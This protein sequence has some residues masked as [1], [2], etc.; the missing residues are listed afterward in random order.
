MTTVAPS[1]AELIKASVPHWAR[2]ADDVDAF[3]TALELGTVADR[4]ADGDGTPL[5]LAR[6][7]LLAGRPRDALTLLAQ[8]HITQLPA[9]PMASWPH[10]LLAACRAAD[11]D[12]G[13][14]RWLLSAVA[15]LP[16][17]W[18]LLYLVGAAAEQRG[19]YG[20]ADQAWTTLVQGHQIVTRFTLA[21]YCAAV[22]ARRDPK[23]PASAAQTL[24]DVV[25]EFLARDPDLTE[26]PQPVLSA[27]A[28]L[29]RRGDNAGSALLLHAAS[30]R[31][32]QAPALKAAVQAVVSRVAMRCY[33]RRKTLL[34]WVHLPLLALAAAAAVWSDL[35]PLVLIGMVPVLLVHRLAAASV[36]GFTTA[37]SAA[38]RAGSRLRQGPAARLLDTEQ[39][40]ACAI[41]VAAVLTATVPIAGALAGAVVG[42]ADAI[43]RTAS[44]AVV[45]GGLFAVL[46]AVLTAIG[47]GL[48]AI[49]RRH[50]WQSARRVRHEADRRRLSDAGD[51]RCWRTSALVGSYAAAYLNRHLTS[52][53]PATWDNER[54]PDATLA[55]C[56]A[57]GTLW[58]ATTA[59]AQGELLLLRGTD[60]ASTDFPVPAPATGGYL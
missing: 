3:R 46:T 51:C 52:S 44:H 23:E 58:L 6:L 12:L 7:L 38:W 33:R 55:R 48:M 1:T 40:F 39:R 5:V 57:T 53:A 22:V 60:R 25:E 21:R 27:A 2:A 10:L 50:N 42:R 41:V 28:H 45:S 36:P 54:F 14:Y 19:D 17:S 20:P 30:Q 56:P 37:D 9:E 31:L 32:P 24:I 8:Q 11:G 34:A 49:M 47:S 29:R 59:G 16:G 26:Y 18:E 4:S 35:P 43:A 13:A 15:A